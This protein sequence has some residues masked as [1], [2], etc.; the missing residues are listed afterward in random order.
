MNLKKSKTV[1][2]L[3]LLSIF[4]FQLA[5]SQHFIRMDDQK[6]I[7]LALDMI[8][9]G[10]QQQDTLKISMVSAPSVSVKQQSLVVNGVLTK[11]FQDIF[12][13]SPKR[14][15]S[16]QKPLINQPNPLT[17]SNIWDFDIV[18][19][20]IEIIEDSA[21]VDCEMVLWGA[22]PAPGSKETGQRI[23]EKF[24]IKSPPRMLSVSSAKDEGGMFANKGARPNRT[25]QLVKFEKL[26]DF[27]K[28]T[29][30]VSDSLDLRIK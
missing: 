20:K 18:N 22:T 19:L 28:T 9:K 8:R 25:W 17:S 16:L 1:F 12:N 23:H 2:L 11:K 27:L 29:G 7:E 30:I 26:L 14:K 24:I 10:V 3:F 6:W 15:L 21:V 13:N 4:S 5:F